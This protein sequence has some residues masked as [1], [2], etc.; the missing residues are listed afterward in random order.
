[1][2]IGHSQRPHLVEFNTHASARKLVGR[3]R[4]CQSAADYA[5]DFFHDLFVYLD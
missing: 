1:M 3:L 4:A 2:G 5:D